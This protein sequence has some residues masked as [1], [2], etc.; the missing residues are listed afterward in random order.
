MRL[1]LVRR[2]RRVVF[3]FRKLRRCRMRPAP[4]VR[5]HI[6]CIR[7]GWLQC[8]FLFASCRLRICGIGCRRPLVPR[9]IP[10]VR[11]LRD[12]SSWRSRLFA[13][14]R[15]SGSLLRFVM[16]LSGLL[17][18]WCWGA[19]LLFTAGGRLRIRFEN[20]PSGLPDLRP[21]WV[22]DVCAPRV[23]R[24]NFPRLHL[25]RVPLASSAGAFA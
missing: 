3:L 13:A 25:G 15:R 19:R 24:G 9:G 11:G 21:G 5:Y 20:M 2:G 17:V 18:V 23:D 4:R 6:R 14:V 7:S 12:S 8:R 1:P 16:A 22:L 10:L